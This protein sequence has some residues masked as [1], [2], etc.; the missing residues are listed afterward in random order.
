MNNLFTNNPSLSS[1]VQQDPN[2]SSFDTNNNQSNFK[3]FINIVLFFLD[4]SS[5]LN[6]NTQSLFTNLNNT[7]NFFNNK[8]EESKIYFNFF[9]T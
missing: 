3:I 6:S 7:N 5:N 2:K 4:N 9:I 8:Q 1:N